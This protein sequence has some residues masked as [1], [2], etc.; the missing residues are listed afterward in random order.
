LSRALIAAAVSALV[1]TGQADAKRHCKKVRV[2]GH[3]RCKR[4]V[5]P[6]PK[7]DLV[8]GAPVAI[9]VLDG[10]TLT[11]SAGTFG[12]TGTMKGFI[13]GK[14]S[15]VSTQM[16][17]ISAMALTPA[18]GAPCPTVSLRPPD[19]GSTAPASM[20]DLNPD[21]TGFASLHLDLPGC[22]GPADLLLAGAIGDGGLFSLPMDSLPGPVTAHLV[23]K[24]DLNSG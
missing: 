20:L 5:K 2:H 15:L 8:I 21:G 16:V 14:V 22:G 23:L 6:K 10:S 18:V 13:P 4:S 1:F 24:V 11:T 19:A 9:T 12:V 3:L 17:A 7:P